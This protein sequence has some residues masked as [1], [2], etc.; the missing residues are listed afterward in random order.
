MEMPRARQERSRPANVKQQK[1][2]AWPPEAKYGTVRFLFAT[3]IFSRLATSCQTFPIS[4]ASIQHGDP[5]EKKFRY[6]RTP[7]TPAFFERI[8]PGSEKLPE[9]RPLAQCHADGFWRRKPARSHHARRRTARRSGRFTR[10]TI[11]DP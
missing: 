10:K 8:I 7:F 9:L 1:F 2:D 4:F 3:G 6:P 5:L 11:Q